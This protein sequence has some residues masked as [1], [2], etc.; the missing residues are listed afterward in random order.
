MSFL[1]EST[2]DSD[3]YSRLRVEGGLWVYDSPIVGV[4]APQWDTATGRIEAV[5]PIATLASGSPAPG[6]AWANV[7]VALA[8]YDTTSNDW[9]DDG[10]ILIHYRLSTGAQAWIYGNIEQ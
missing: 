10:K 5:I 9:D 4:I 8:F 3:A 6:S 7:V 1:A 2:S